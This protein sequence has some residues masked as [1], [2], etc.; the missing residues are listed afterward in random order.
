[1]N[2]VGRVGKDAL[3]DC[4]EVSAIVLGMVA[5]LLLPLA[6]LVP[7][8]CQ[9][10]RRASS[11]VP[12]LLLHLTSVHF[13]LPLKNIQNCILKIV[14]LFIIL[15]AG[16]F[17]SEVWYLERV[18]GYAI[19]YQRVSHDE[20]KQE[21]QLESLPLLIKPPVPPFSQPHLTLMTS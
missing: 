11:K 9:I 10:F 17:K 7:C 13:L 18:S 8:L 20:A 12:V 3:E 21:C 4:Q 5:P 1:M 14:H 16:K 2:S 15:E 6:L 19:T